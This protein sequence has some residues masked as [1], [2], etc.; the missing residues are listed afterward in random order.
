MVSKT[1]RQCNATTME[2][3]PPC[4]FEILTI[5]CGTG[6]IDDS[7]QS[8]FH[9]AYGKRKSKIFSAPKLGVGHFGHC[10]R[11]SNAACPDEDILALEIFPVEVQLAVLAPSSKTP[12]RLERLWGLPGFR[13]DTVGQWLSSETIPLACSSLVRRLTSQPSDTTESRVHVRG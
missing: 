9:L 11:N 10:R 7:H 12:L 2:K 8:R 13:R 5:T 6:G 3:H 1:L 4:A